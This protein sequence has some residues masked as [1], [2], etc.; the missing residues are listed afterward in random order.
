M[1]DAGL[2]KPF[3]ALGEVIEPV[4]RQLLAAEYLGKTVRFLFAVAEK[5]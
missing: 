5:V 2:K 4:N 3:L 1:P